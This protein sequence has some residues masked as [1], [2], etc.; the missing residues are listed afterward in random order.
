M[1]KKQQLIKSI[2][3]TIVERHQLTDM[4]LINAQHFIS[5]RLDTHGNKGYLF[6]MVVDYKRQYIKAEDNINMIA[7][8]VAENNHIE[9]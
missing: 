4:Q 6:K 3:A 2:M 9:H 1:T 8:Y 7:D 5:S